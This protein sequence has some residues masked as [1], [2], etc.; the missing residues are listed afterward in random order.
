MISNL[1][2]W[3]AAACATLACLFMFLYFSLRIRH[4]RIRKS[5]QSATESFAKQ[6]KELEELKKQR[7]DFSEDFTDTQAQS[8]IV[9]FNQEGKIT[10]VNDYAQEFFG[11]KKSELIGKSVLGTIAPE[12]KKKYI[13]Q[14]TLIE[15]ILL[16]P[17]LYVDVETKNLKKDG[18][19]VW[20]SWTNRVVYDEKN[21][22]IEIRSVGFDITRRKQLEEK[23]NYLTSMD[24][25]TGVLN[26]AAFLREGEKEMKRAIR[27]NRTLSL[28]LLK[29]DHFRVLGQ[30]FGYSF[31]DEALKKTV[32]IC[33]DSIRDSDYLGRIGDV[34]FAIL[35]PETP[36]EN[37]PFLV[38]RLRLK[39]QDQNLKTEIGNAFITTAFGTAG[40]ADDKDSV[41]AMLLR[42]EQNLKEQTQKNK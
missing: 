12:P 3:I 34:E 28:L 22:P 27:Y 10:Y 5:L 20:I 18:S 41:D 37:V 13:A 24:P 23:L 35:L 32:K 9:A 19:P 16:N 26:R 30:E 25:L 7:T 38:E 40:K 8:I 31:G 42:A 15:K 36:V 17:Q 39:I 29:L 33:K 1:A 14:P 2:S 11:F 21:K 6:T 4:A